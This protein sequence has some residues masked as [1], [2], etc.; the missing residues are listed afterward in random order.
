MSA[1]SRDPSVLKCKQCCDKLN[2]FWNCW[3]RSRINLFT[4][5]CVFFRHT[6]THTHTHS[7]CRACLKTRQACYNGYQL[8]CKFCSDLN[9][10]V[11]FVGCKQ[12]AVNEGHEIPLVSDH[13][14]RLQFVN[15]KTEAVTFML[16]NLKKEKRKTN[17]NKTNL[18]F[19]GTRVQNNL[20]D[21]QNRRGNY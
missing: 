16:A 1:N 17:L 9:A 8:T 18:R 11:K 2:I 15:D 6:H 5:V 13:L 19:I 4:N 3:S 14:R 12:D 7:E 10:L 21:L 20:H